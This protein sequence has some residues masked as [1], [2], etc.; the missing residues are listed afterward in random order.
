VNRFGILCAAGLVAGGVLVSG[1]S[2]SIPA[3]RRGGGDSVT[4]AFEGWY[5][6]PDG[7]RSFLVGYYN[8]FDI[9]ELKVNRSPRPPATFVDQPRDAIKQLMPPEGGHG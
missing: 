9:F 1:Q 4:G 3:P 8:R 7:S 5:Y 6:N 2:T